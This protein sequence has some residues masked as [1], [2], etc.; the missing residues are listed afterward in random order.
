MRDRYSEEEERDM[1]ETAAK[2][3]SICCETGGMLALRWRG[4]LDPYF[5]LLSFFSSGGT[6]WREP[7]DS[8]TFYKRG[9]DYGYTSL[10]WP[11]PCCIRGC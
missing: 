5:S 4:P 6:F 3:A 7:E 8:D 11:V 10:D 1:E 2:P 9:E